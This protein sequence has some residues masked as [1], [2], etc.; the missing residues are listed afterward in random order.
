MATSV[1]VAMSEIRQLSAKANGFYFSAND[2][3][4]LRPTLPSSVPDAGADGP[5]GLARARGA[6]CAFGGWRA[7]RLGRGRPRSRLWRRKDRR[8]V[9][10]LPLP[11]NGDKRR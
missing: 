7:R 9:G 6:D 3:P 11:W 4:P 10:V 2:L 1:R 8:G 5:W